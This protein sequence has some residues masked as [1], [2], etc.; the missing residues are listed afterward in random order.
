Q[1]DRIVYAS[2]ASVFG[3]PSFYGDGSLDSDIEL[4]P[5]SH[6]G[7]FKVCNES[8]ARVY[9]Q[10]HAISSIALR[11]WTVYGVGRDHG[12]TAAPT[13]A[14]KAVVLRRA[15]HIAYGGWQDLQYVEDV[16]AAFVRCLEAPYRGAGAYN[17]RGVPIEM[18]EFIR[19]LA[20][21]EP[22][23]ARLVSHGDRQ[24]EI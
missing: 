16:A 11:P 24:L 19:A 17:L 6:Y 4:R 20:S 23:A 2:S 7:A 18:T 13:K 21:V 22:E 10:D 12:M 5:S 1:V 8:N 3:P 15:Y 9:W 14:I